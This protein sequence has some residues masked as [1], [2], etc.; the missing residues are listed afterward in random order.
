MCVSV[1]VCVCVC[2]SVCVSVCVCVCVCL[3]VYYICTNTDAR[4]ALRCIPFFGTWVHLLSST[5]T[6]LSGK[7]GGGDPEDEHA[8][9]EC[10][11]LEG[12]CARLEALEARLGGAGGGGLS[13]SRG[14]GEGVSE[15]SGARAGGRKH[16]IS[17]NGQT[18]KKCKLIYYKFST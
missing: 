17:K 7:S 12:V 5:V 2:V 16:K 9:L 15:G 4:L 1:C 8:R 6:M 11:R 18:T 14:G 13:R 3:C 10:A